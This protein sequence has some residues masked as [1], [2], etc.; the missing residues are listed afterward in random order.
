MKTPLLLAA[1]LMAV[2]APL[3]AGAHPSAQHTIE[4]L[5]ESIRAQPDLQEF[6]IRRGQAYSNEGL[7]EPALVDF[8]K[9]E[10]LGPPILVAF[11]LGVLH[12]RMGR[13][14]DARRYLDAFLKRF[15]KNAP[16]LE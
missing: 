12:Y 8:Q 3:R 14:D 6:Y 5:S 2:A 13:L 10:T 1:L 11:D 16:A 9:A 15:P 7:P 4:I